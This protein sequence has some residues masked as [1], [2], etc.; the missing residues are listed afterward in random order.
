MTPVSWVGDSNAAGVRDPAEMNG[1]GI[2]HWTIV[3]RSGA[4]QLGLFGRRN[5][6]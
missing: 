3:P 1:I 2:R 4:H 6:F 5:Q